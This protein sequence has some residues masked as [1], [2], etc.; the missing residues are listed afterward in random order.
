MS[1]HHTTAVV[2][3]NTNKQAKRYSLL[4]SSIPLNKT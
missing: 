1:S 4:S 2:P 3:R